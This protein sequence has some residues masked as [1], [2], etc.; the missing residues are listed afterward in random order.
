VSASHLPPHRPF[1]K[2]GDPVIDPLNRR[3]TI[4]AKDG[5]EATIRCAGPHGTTVRY[6]VSCL[7]WAGENDR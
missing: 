7:R 3:V 6:P 4:I 5:D 2:V 1:F